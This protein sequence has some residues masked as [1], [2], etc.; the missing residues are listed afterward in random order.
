MDWQEASSGFKGGLL[1]E[2]QRKAKNF[3]FYKPLL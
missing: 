3:L 1:A 2:F